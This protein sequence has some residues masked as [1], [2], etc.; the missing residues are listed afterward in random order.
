ME[1]T[2]DRIILKIII[3]LS[4]DVSICFLV[5]KMIIDGIL[6]IKYKI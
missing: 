5:F 1:C 6:S 2:Q 4:I 3:H